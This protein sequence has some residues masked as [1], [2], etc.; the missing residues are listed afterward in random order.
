M[1]IQKPSGTKHTYE[2][3]PSKNL[4]PEVLADLN[5]ATNERKKHAIDS[6]HTLKSS[7]AW[8]EQKSIW[9]NASD[10]ERR[11]YLYGMIFFD[12]VPASTKNGMGLLAKFFGIKLDELKPYQDVIDMADAARV[13]H[14]NRNQFSTFMQRDDNPMG[15]FFMG[16]QFGYQ[17]NDPAHEGVD[18]VQSAP[19]AIIVNEIKADNTELRQELDEMARKAIAGVNKGKSH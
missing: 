14:I 9:P 2:D 16:K 19:P 17:V 5:N 1:A 6:K 8:K 7:D 12:A 15:K 3:K 10:D 11:C 13:L 4:T 18:S